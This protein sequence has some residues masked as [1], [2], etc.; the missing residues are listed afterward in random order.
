MT[1][2]SNG[3]PPY[4]ACD[5]NY[6]LA[7]SS[8]VC[9]NFG[10]TRKSVAAK[11]TRPPDTISRLLDAAEKLFGEHG[12]DG[13]GM[14]ALATASKVNLGAAT[15]HFGSKRALYIETFM[16]RFRP[17]NAERLTLLRE[18]EAR[19]EGRALAVEQ[20]VDC[21][22]RPSYFLGLTHPGFNA[23]LTRNFATPPAFL[24]V[25][26]YRE[27]ESSVREFVSALHRSLAHLPAEL[28]QL[29]AVFSMGPLFAISAQIERMAALR[30][31]ALHESIFLEL[32]RFISAGLSSEPA[33]PTVRWPFTSRL[34]KGSR[35]HVD[36]MAKKGEMK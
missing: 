14:R 12:Y 27:F 11:T 16:R 17:I 10:M 4:G 1:Q 19:A 7:Y 6:G 20:I 26:F 3:L 24:R 35:V 9:I 21:M 8:Y 5:A 31:P 2:S 32:V 33:A 34:S 18:A 15:Y 25:A 29:R 30:D 23:L 22:L 36:F 28:I 13:V